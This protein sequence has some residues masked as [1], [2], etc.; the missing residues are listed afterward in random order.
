MLSVSVYTLPVL[1]MG[2]FAGSMLPSLLMVM[3]G[4]Y[5]AGVIPI[6][7]A[8]AKLTNPIPAIAENK[9]AKMRVSV[10]AVFFISTKIIIR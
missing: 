2:T 1:L 10:D 6:G 5:G 4:R 8:T 3:E 9:S 7:F